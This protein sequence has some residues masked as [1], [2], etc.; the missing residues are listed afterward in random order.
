MREQP[1]D[2]RNERRGRG[3]RRKEEEEEE[4]IVEELKKEENFFFF[5]F[6]FYF[7]FFLPFFVKN[8]AIVKEEEKRHI[9]DIYAFTGKTKRVDLILIIKITKKRGKW[10]AARPPF[11]TAATTRHLRCD[12]SVIL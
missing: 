7:Y 5:C 10:G 6:V 4:E 3:R 9:K 11:V 1:T 8:K 12:P 2:V